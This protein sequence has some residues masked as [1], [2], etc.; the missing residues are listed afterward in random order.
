MHINGASLSSCTTPVFISKKGVSPSGNLTI[1]RVC[2][3]IINMAFTISVGRTNIY[4]YD[5]LNLS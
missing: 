1:E 2:L 4:D 3:Y 5:I